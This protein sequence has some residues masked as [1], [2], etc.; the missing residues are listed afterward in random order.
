MPF[1]KPLKS[2]N[3]WLSKD[4]KIKMLVK[5]KQRSKATLGLLL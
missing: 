2:G 5:N 1:E 4:W 3:T